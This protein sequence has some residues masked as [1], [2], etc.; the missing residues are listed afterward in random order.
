M[1]KCACSILF[2][3]ALFQI[4]LCVLAQKSK[5][6]NVSPASFIWKDAELNKDCSAR[7]IENSSLRVTH[8]QGKCSPFRLPNS[9]WWSVIVESIKGDEHRYR[10]IMNR[11]VGRSFKTSSPIR[12]QEDTDVPLSSAKGGGNYIIK[13][14]FGTPI[15]NFYLEVDTGSDIT[16][17]PCAPCS[18]CSSALFSPSKSSTYKYLTC[19]SKP[20]QDL[21]ICGNDKNSNCSVGERYGDQSE[22][23]QLM[24]S[25]TLSVS[26]QYVKDFVFGCAYSLKG[27]L[28][29][30]SPGLIGFGRDSV[31]FV[32]QTAALY[33]RTFSYCLP[34]L[35]SSAFTGSLRLGKTALSIPGLQFTPLLSNA[36]LP[37]FYFLG[38]TG[39]SVGEELISIPAGTGKGTI[40]DSGT[41]ISRLVEPAYNAMRDSFRRQMSNL[42][43]A[44]PSEP[45]DTCYKV[46]SKA[47]KFPVITLHF[48]NSL[49]LSLPMENTLF[50]GNARG[51]VLCLAF[52]L[53]PDGGDSNTVSIIGNYQQQ[54][55]RVVHDVPGSRLG[56][57]SEN[58]DA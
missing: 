47:V 11:S 36:Q 27:P 58:C 16:W 22:V 56:I 44:R 15:Q 35:G 6:A 33:D 57:A 17:I 40:I 5:F 41:V 43:L 50:P 1:A 20:C 21:G 4:I 18:S 25:E 29:Q 23:D 42:T 3:S 19:A 13:L 32:S 37:P 10:A 14:G 54:N 2:I 31:S 34:S 38:L 49:D 28:I 52:A 48:E 8:I 53:P 24:S 51:S 46:P 12:P 9:T 45:F 39:I 30:S 55:F 7:E 26:S